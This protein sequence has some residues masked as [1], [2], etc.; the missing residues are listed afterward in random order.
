[1]G[2]LRIEKK[3][4]RFYSSFV[5]QNVCSYI[6]KERVKEIKDFNFTQE[7]KNLMLKDCLNIVNYLQGNKA[8]H[9]GTHTSK[10]NGDIELDN[11]IIELKYVGSGNGTYYNTS[12]EYFSS[13]GL[14]SYRDFLA[15]NDYLVFLKENTGIEPSDK[16]SPYSL[17]I[18]N[19]IRKD[20][21]DI[22]NLI[23]RKEKSLRAIYTIY[24]ISQLKN[25]PDLS[26]RV[27][28]DML[29]KSYGNKQ[30]PDRMIVYNYISKTLNDIKGNDLI[31]NQNTI[32]PLKSGDYSIKL[33]N[34]RLTLGWQNGTGLNNPTIRVFL[35]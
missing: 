22:Y 16:I 15:E 21:P 24:V 35:I 33:G 14:K 20:M 18:A 23:V 32:V 7:E 34:L 28:Y 30:L 31:Q 8:V 29:N 1:M 4:N 25:N 11:Q 13:I 2:V 27:Y 5:E 10:T 3:N 26:Y 12:I 6:N 17:K 19:D 9:I